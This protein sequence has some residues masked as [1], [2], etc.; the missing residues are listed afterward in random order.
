[1]YYANCVYNLF[2]S[3]GIC[4]AFQPTECV[5][6]L[7]FGPNTLQKPPCMLFPVFMFLCSLLQFPSSPLITPHPL[8][9]KSHIYIL[10]WW[11]RPHQSCSTAA[12]WAEE[13]P[14]L[15]V[16]FSRSGLDS[17]QYRW[18]FPD[19]HTYSVCP[20]LARLEKIERER[21]YQWH[22]CSRLRRQRGSWK[23]VSSGGRRGGGC[24]ASLILHHKH[25]S[26]LCVVKTLQRHSVDLILPNLQSAWNLNFSQHS[27]A[28]LCLS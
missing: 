3:K 14:C 19:L 15:P 28:R 24:A 13:C 5:V 25:Q 2:T 9:L 21:E 23:T 7:D 16:L 22:N 1:M 11:G 10:L 26:T 12:S 18:S 6:L 17:L 27:C 4:W 20:S 8:A